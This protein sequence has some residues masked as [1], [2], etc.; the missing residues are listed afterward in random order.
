MPTAIE[1]KE[2]GFK[3]KE[4]TEYLRKKIHTRQ[5]AGFTEEEIDTNLGLNQ[6][7][8][9]KLSLAPIKHPTLY[10]IKETVKDIPAQ[11]AVVGERFAKGATLGLT[12]EATNARKYLEERSKEAGFDVTVPSLAEGAG[13]FMGAFYPIGMAGKVIATPVKKAFVLIPKLPPAVK[14]GLGRTVGW[15]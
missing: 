7:L 15:G 11:A 4:I 9:E 10:A 2:A 12:P 8:K 13:K 5:Q 1:L 3:D 6:K 14:A